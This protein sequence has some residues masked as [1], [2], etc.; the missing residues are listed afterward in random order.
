MSV[1][2]HITTH[3]AWQHARQQG[4]YRAPSLETEGFI[5]CSHARQVAGVAERLFAGRDDLVLLSIDVEMLGCPVH[6]E[7]APD[8]PG[9]R[10][11]HV[12][13]EINLDA[14]VRMVDYRPDDDGRFPDPD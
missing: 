6:D 14:I 3:A 11:P 12:Y 13:G 7:P 4:V 2:H 5:H 9:E 1:I 8:V 10:F